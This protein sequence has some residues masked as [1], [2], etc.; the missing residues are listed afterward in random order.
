MTD[1]PVSSWAYNTIQS[2]RR[3]LLKIIFGLILFGLWIVASWTLWALRQPVPQKVK[4]IGQIAGRGDRDKVYRLV[5][6]L[7]DLVA[8]LPAALFGWSGV[9]A[10]LALSPFFIN[11]AIYRP[12][13]ADQ[14]PTRL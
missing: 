8:A 5:I 1:W 13:S 3:G 14:L 9:A 10:G 12:L 11:A 2:T 6:A 4:I 7:F